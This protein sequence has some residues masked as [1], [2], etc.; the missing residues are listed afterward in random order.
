[1]PGYKKNIS[2]IALA[3]LCL[4]MAAA[5]VSCSSWGKSEKKKDNLSASV[6]AFNRAF[7]WEDYTA[8]VLF[9]SPLNKMQFWQEVDVFKGKIR[10]IDI[11]IR[12]IDYIEDSPSAFIT[13]YAQFYRP[14]APTLQTV[15]FS[16]KWQFSEK[17]KAWLVKERGFEAIIKKTTGL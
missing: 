17:E 6:D 14:N 13:L 11:Q 3:A 7:K 10:I 5:V 1:M 9:I 2:K 12:D 4:F 16:Q 15:T 8:A